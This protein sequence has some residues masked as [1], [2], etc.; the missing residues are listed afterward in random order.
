[1]DANRPPA[2]TPEPQANLE[3]IRS[4]LRLALLTVGIVPM[5]AATGVMYAVA[6]KA[7]PLQFLVILP[8]VVLLLVPIVLWLP[9]HLLHVTERLEKSSAEMRR[10]Y[11]VAREASLRD[12]LTGLGN[13]RA[14]Q[15]ELDRQLDWYNR[16]RVK[17]ALLLID[18][19]DLKLVNDSEGHAAGDEMLRDLGTLIQQS[20]RYADRAFRIGGDEFA[21]LM[22][23]TDAAGA[24]QIAQRLQQRAMRP[25]AKGRPIPF[26]AGI[27]V[28]PELATTRSALYAQADAALYWCKRHG[29]SSIDVFDASRDRGPNVEATSE[30][31]ASIARVI[32][33]SRLRPVYQPIVE[34]TTGRVIGF[35]GLIRPAAESGF[36]DPA[37]LF[38][39][40]DSVG[41]TVELDQACLQAVV[42]GARAMPVDQLLTLNV[43]PRTVEAPHFSADSLLA[44]LVRNGIAPERV[45]VELTE[46]ES[47][48][49]V[50][51]LQSNL[52][53]LQRAGVRVAADDVGAGNAGLR[54]LSQFRF[55]IVKIDLTLVQDSTER[56]SS[57]AVLRSLRDLAGRWGASVIAEG[58]ETVS[59]LRTVR[60]L[61]MT[62][63]Q[64]Y[65]LGR[66]MPNPVLS[67]V[68]LAAIE[69]GATILAHHLGADGA[70]SAAIS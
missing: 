52:A 15:E 38:Q 27:S 9:R 28:C 49:D 70:F 64:G 5:V 18:L 62:A 61:G 42:A 4:R 67:T 60:E 69:A 26:S 53:A 3:R 44:I 35:E 33:D 63:G 47:V 59:Q 12:A 7:V 14:F 22:P 20:V 11:E 2:S 19:D 13:H 56:A 65:L 8:V 25:S 40:A 16:Y 68:D 36:A 58:L 46:R 50:L 54:L 48:E 1:L 24:L 51:R 41:R 17:V 39:A 55:D 66:P 34:L 29:R 10:L 45:V 23:H 6:P 43:S 31:S 21:V 57:R 37:S 30:L 32:T